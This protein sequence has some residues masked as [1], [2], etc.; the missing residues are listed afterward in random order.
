MFR[1]YDQYLTVKINQLCVS[2]RSE[3]TGVDSRHAPASGTVPSCAGP[4]VLAE[5][6]I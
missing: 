1:P 6:I 2:S 5:Q 3:L 4:A